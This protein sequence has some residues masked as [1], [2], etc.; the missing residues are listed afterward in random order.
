MPRVGIRM[1]PARSISLDGVFNS[2]VAVNL[3]LGG[4]TPLKFVQ[5]DRV[6]G[7]R[8]RLALRDGWRV[9]GNLHTLGYFAGAH[10]PTGSKRTQDARA[11]FLLT[12]C[13]N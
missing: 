3:T 1:T 11:R 7:A 8:R 2:P 4:F 9:D 5:P 6:D 12:H 10:S 13:S